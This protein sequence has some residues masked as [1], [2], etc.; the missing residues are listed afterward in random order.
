MLSE[1]MRENTA[2]TK[3]GLDR[4]MG[5]ASVVSPGFG[6]MGLFVRGRHSFLPSQLLHPSVPRV[7]PS[8]TTTRQRMQKNA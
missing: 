4:G 7:C 3:A 2:V 5:S 1:Y 8:A 6:G